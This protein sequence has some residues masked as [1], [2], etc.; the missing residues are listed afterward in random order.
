MEQAFS[1]PRFNSDV[2]PDNNRVQRTSLKPTTLPSTPPPILK[3]HYILANF[4]S[5]RLGNELFR[6]ASLIGIA[7]KHRYMPVVDRHIAS[8][9]SIFN[10]SIRVI[11]KLN[12]SRRFSEKAAGKYDTRIHNISTHYNWTLNGYF[13]SWKYFVNV[14]QTLRKEFQFL[15]HIIKEAK[16][17]LPPRYK[18]LIGVH[19]RRGDMNSLRQIKR[20]YNVADIGYLNRSMG[21]FRHTLG[22][23]S[24]IVVSDDINWCKKY[25]QMPDVKIVR[26]SHVVDL[27]VL[28]LCDHN[29]VTTGTFG[30]WG[31]WLAGGKTVYFKNFPKNDTWLDKQY[32]KSDYYPPH[33]V[34]M[35]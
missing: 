12:N 29:I 16:Q 4:D 13:Q 25:L 15:P 30:W 8:I 31:A 5:G 17:L 11:K 9:T 27:A 22:S 14:T 32:E 28:S 18:P 24:F 3:E 21:Y 34:G 2:Q 26:G 7:D 6:L 19:V 35:L 1:Y 23:V 10:S 33:W 20:G